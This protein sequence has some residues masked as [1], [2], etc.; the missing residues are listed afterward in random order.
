MKIKI[1]RIDKELPLPEYKTSGA[2]AFDLYA[3]VTTTILPHFVSYVPLNVAIEIPAGH[4][5]LLAPRSSLHKKGLMLANSVGIVDQDYCGN[6][7]E[8][9]AALYNFSEAP[10][11]ISRGERLLQGIIKK[12]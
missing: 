3:R 9:L 7:D 6:D 10:V 12:Y 8:Y 2:V 1:R 4:M 11:S 5:I